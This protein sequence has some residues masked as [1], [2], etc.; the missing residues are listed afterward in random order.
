MQSIR[1]R[2]EAVFINNDDRT[3]TWTSHA[4]EIWQFISILLLSLVTGVFWGSWLGLS[5]SMTSLS[6]E[7]FVEVAH[8]MIGNLGTVM[9]VLMPA[10]M[11]T[12]VPVLYLLYRRR[13]KTFYPTAAGFALFV[14]ALLITL[15][16]EVPLDMQFQRWTATTLPSNWEALRANWEWWHAIRSWASVAGLALMLAGAL[17]GIGTQVERRRLRRVWTQ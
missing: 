5:R 1:D 17:L 3:E 2:R 14:V 9:A 7:T 11:L 8:A 10:A 15:A 6:K 12:A 13:S 16:V 4:L